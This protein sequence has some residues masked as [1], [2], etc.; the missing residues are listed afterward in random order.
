MCCDR[1]CVVS[2]ESSCCL[3]QREGKWRPTTILHI[4]QRIL[5]DC[6][7]FTLLETLSAIVGVCAVFGSWGAEISQLP[8]EVKHK[9]YQVGGIPPGLHTSQTQSG[10][11]EQGRWCAQPTSD[12]SD[13]YERRS[14]RVQDIE[15]ALW[16]ISWL[17]INVCHATEKVCSRDGRVSV[18]RRIFI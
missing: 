13:S 14:D 12:D 8:K 7:C 18:T 16:V 1:W 9:I 4:W 15:R 17:W 5:R 2:G 11:W 6:T 10:S 3:F